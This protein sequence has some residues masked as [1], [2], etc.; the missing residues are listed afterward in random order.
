M[1]PISP[2]TPSSMNSPLSSIACMSPL[3]SLSSL[4]SMVGSNP[5][6]AG[7]AKNVP[8]MSTGENAKNIS[9]PFSNCSY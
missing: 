9:L 1:S 3:S 8:G 7:G 6:L 5:S 2:M 4:S